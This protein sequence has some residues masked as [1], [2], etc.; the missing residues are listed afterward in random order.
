MT[1]LLVPR[2]HRTR[3]RAAAGVALAAVLAVGAAACG[4]DADDPLA[5][6]PTATPTDP[7]D[8]VPDTTPDVL[9]LDGRTF[10]STATSGFDLVAGTTV[11]IQ[12]VDGRF[13][14]SAGC[15]ILGATYIVDG[16]ELRVDGGIEMT[17]MGCEEPLMAQDSR[18][19]DLLGSSPTIT[20]DGDALTI[21]STLASITFLD[22]EVADPDRPLEGTLWTLTS[23]VDG[24]SAS[25][26]P[27]DAVSTIQLVDGRLLVATGCNTGSASAV[28]AG[29]TLVL[30]P[31]ALTKMACDDARMQLEAAVVAVLD[32]TVG[33][34]IEA[35]TL[36]LT[37]GDR[38]L[39]Y[40]ATP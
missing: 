15:N 40:T 12:F 1:F 25:S 34:A 28:V 23:V 27:T 21:A 33:V 31:L 22:R 24:E 9:P 14:A 35:G 6:E 32:G 29:D 18:L 26:L 3:S 20:L 5:T 38:G 30:G 4:D 17:E 39:A 11:R 8:T 7:E 16:R 10:L 36:T 2:R 19:V 37:S 13:S